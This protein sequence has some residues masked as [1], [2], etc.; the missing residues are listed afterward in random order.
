MNL[1]FVE[2]YR[3]SSLD[4]II[5]QTDIISTIDKFIKAESL[6][7]LLFYGT[8]G[9][10][11]STM[12]IN[13]A[14]RIYEKNM[15]SFVLELNASDDRGIDV[16]RNQ[17]KEF[18]QTKSLGNKH[19]LIILD[20]A[21][22][23][24]NVAQGALR[25]IIEKYTSNVRFIIICNFANKIIPALQ[26]RCTRF[27]FAPLDSKDIK[28]KVR[29]VCMAENIK[30]PE[31]AVDALI[32][33]SN[34]DMRCILNILQGLSIRNKEIQI[35]DVYEMMGLPS[36]ANLQSILKFI[37]NEPFSVAYQGTLYSFR[38]L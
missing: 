16:V 34:G 23:L 19:K 35:N 25:R 29:E 13:I 11:K 21:D 20:E 37:F 10:G 24:T 33:I 38:S 18:S 9:T 22:H 27:R 5:S 12:A 7:H 2:K 36:E 31:N 8:A 26:S 30:I 4:Q 1:P 17:I 32:K 3:P 14:R 15:A 6:P 28:I